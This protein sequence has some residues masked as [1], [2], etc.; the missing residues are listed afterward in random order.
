MKMKRHFAVFGDKI[1]RKSATLSG[2]ICNNVANAVIKFVKSVILAFN[3]YYVVCG[4]TCQLKVLFLYF[5]TLRNLKC[6]TAD[7][8]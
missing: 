5:I 6:L 3:F 8:S 2:C 1:Q 7:A 4:C